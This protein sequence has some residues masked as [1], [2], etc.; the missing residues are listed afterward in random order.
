MEAVLGLASLVKVSKKLDNFSMVSQVE[1]GIGFSLSL[2]H[3]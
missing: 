1:L 3:I 2:I